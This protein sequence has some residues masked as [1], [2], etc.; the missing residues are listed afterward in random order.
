MYV[1]CDTSSAVNRSLITAF[2]QYLNIMFWALI[3]FFIHVVSFRWYPKSSIRITAF[4]DIFVTVYTVVVVIWKKGWFDLCCCRALT[5]SATN[6]LSLFTFKHQHSIPWHLHIFSHYINLIISSTTYEFIKLQIFFSTLTSYILICDMNKKLDKKFFSSY[7]FS[8]SFRLLGS[9]ISCQ[10]LSCCLIDSWS[11]G[12]HQ[13]EKGR[14]MLF[15]SLMVRQYLRQV[16][17]D[18]PQFPYNL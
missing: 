12:K 3:C 17:S 4:K 13:Q 18:S 16:I 8:P 1:I 7:T 10:C 9:L 11:I 2:L 6:F 5:K 15:Q 14:K